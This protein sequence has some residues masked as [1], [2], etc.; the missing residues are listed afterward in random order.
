M[1][2]ALLLFV[3]AGAVLI[4]LFPRLSAGP[5]LDRPRAAELDGLRLVSWNLENWFDKYD[6]PYRRDE[7]TKPAY[8][9]ESRQERCAAVLRELNGDIVALQE[10]ENRFVLQQFVDTYLSGMGYQVVLVE[11]NDSRGIDCALL[12]KLP[13]DAVTSYRHR[14]FAGADG[15]PQRFRRDLLRV[16]LGAPLEGD[17]YVVHLKS[18]HGGEAADIVREAESAEVLRIVRENGMR[19]GG[20]R[21]VV[22]GDF[23][24]VPELPTITQSVEGGLVDSMAGTERYTYNKEP[25]LTRIDFALMSGALASEVAT[26][27]VINE[28][29]NH[30]LEA[31]SDH[32]PLLVTF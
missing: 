1:Q 15:G 11:G 20:Y 2:R 6:D 16:S 26:A 18:Q 25:Y 21:A 19:D 10:V 5:G 32:Y 27:E 17:I 31:C 3:L 9:N 12:T 8:I 4:G 22:I 29:G 23:N 28:L 7:V 14:K 24:E 13:I 30:R